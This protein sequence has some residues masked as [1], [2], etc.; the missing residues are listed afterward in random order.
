MWDLKA[1]DFSI[2]LLVRTLVNMYTSQQGLL[3][4]FY[5]LFS[6][7]ESEETWKKKERKKE[8]VN[9]FSLRCEGF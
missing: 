6:L 5:V 4:P 7:E 3:F 8:V 9:P 2:S 1:L